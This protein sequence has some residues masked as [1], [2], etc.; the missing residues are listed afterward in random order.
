M[1]NANKDNKMTTY[2]TTDNWS[3]LLPLVVDDGLAICKYVKS[4]LTDLHTDSV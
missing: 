2:H 1:L 3:L 4:I